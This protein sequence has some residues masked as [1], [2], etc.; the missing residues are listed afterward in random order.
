MQL[1]CNSANVS[2][3]RGWI[4]TRAGVHVVSAMITQRT[5]PAMAASIAAR[6]G[7]MRS[8]NRCPI[9]QKT[10]TSAATEINHSTPT[11]LGANPADYG[12]AVGHRVAA[13]DQ[14]GNK[15][16]A[17]IEREPQQLF[18]RRSKAAGTRIRG[19]RFRPEF[20]LSG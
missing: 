15:D 8:S 10:A 12:K 2:P 7:P 13:E 18:R 1:K 11:V 20:P 19:R 5:M 3:V 16:D 14:G 4:V 6:A 17:A 9:K